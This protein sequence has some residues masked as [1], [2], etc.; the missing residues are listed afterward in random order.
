[1]SNEDETRQPSAVV[2][3]Q[4]PFERDFSLLQGRNVLLSAGDIH[5]VAM[6]EFLKE[7][8]KARGDLAILIQNSIDKLADQ[9][10]ITKLEAQILRS[11]T[12]AKELAEQKKFSGVVRHFRYI[13]QNLIVGCASPLAIAI[14]SIALDSALTA[15]QQVDDNEQHEGEGDDTKPH[16]P[17]PEARPGDPF[18]D[19]IG[20]DILGGVVGGLIGL[21]G[22]P[23][24]A[25]IGA[26][27][28]AALLSTPSE[29]R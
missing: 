20:P 6:R 22:G 10:C 2:E 21:I 11:L 4:V 28:G 25:V 29:A 14:A 19:V 16:E 24:G 27:V 17:Q 9:N 15:Y 1:M 18:N 13:H 12:E 7:R 23:K 8:R 26:I 3:E 5:G